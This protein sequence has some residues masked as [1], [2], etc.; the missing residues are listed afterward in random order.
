MARLDRRRLATLQSA[1]ARAASA[2]PCAQDAGERG[3]HRL[4]GGRIRAAA[5]RCRCHPHN[6]RQRRGHPSDHDRPRIARRSCPARQRRGRAPRPVRRLRRRWRP[7]MSGS[8]AAFASGAGTEMSATAPPYR[9]SSRDPRRGRRGL[10]PA[11][12]VTVTS[13]SRGRCGS[14]GRGDA[15]AGHG[16]QVSAN[17]RAGSRPETKVSVQTTLATKPVATLAVAGA[18]GGQR[19]RARAVVLARM[20]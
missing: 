3:D 11:N 18:G 20:R 10:G 13:L 6:A 8:S 15:G 16:R 14:R 5:Y 7:A 1:Q 19:E 9:D 17:T 4:G 12:S 2:R